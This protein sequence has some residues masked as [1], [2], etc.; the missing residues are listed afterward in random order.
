MSI[1]RHTGIQIQHT[2]GRKDSIHTHTV[3][4]MS[5]THTRARTHRIQRHQQWR[6]LR[7]GASCGTRGGEEVVSFLWFSILPN[8]SPSF[9]QMCTRRDM[10]EAVVW[11]SLA[12]SG[13]VDGGRREKRRKK[14]EEECLRRLPHLLPVGALCAGSDCQRWPPKSSAQSLWSARQLKDL[15]LSW[16]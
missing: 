5:I 6:W 8:I 2:E 16:K 11:R 13:L 10:A 4:D 9:T 12:R 7:P 14:G 1:H 15:Q 3:C